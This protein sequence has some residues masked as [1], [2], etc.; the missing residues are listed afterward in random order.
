MRLPAIDLSNDVF[1]LDE[2]EEV[3]CYYCMQ[4]GQIS[5]YKRGG[6]Y[7]CGPTHSPLDGNANYICLRHLDHDAVLPDGSHPTAGD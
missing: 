4:E 6:A 3:S 1:D 7:L 5:N 2:G